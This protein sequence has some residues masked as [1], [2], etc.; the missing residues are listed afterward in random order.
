MLAGNGARDA[1]R[2]REVCNAHSGGGYFR[3][4][5]AQMVLK[6]NKQQL[7]KIGVCEGD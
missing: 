4:A 2:A 5:I 6:S 7:I 1:E 3:G